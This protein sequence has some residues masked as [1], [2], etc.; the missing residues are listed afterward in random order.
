M[1]TTNCT[2]L[3]LNDDALE[4][5]SGGFSLSQ[6]LSNIGNSIAETTKTAVGIG[7]YMG[8]PGILGAGAAGAILGAINGV[9]NEAASA[10]QEAFNALK[11]LG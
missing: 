9:K 3:E 8:P 2:S 11:N 6:S 7:L 10:A 1:N 5:V 4:A